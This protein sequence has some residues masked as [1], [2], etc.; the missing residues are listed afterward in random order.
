MKVE[1][2]SK[3]AVLDLIDAKFPNNPAVISFYTPTHGRDKVDYQNV[4]DNVFYVGV[5]DIGLESLSEYGYS[6]DMFLSEADD[7]A[8]FIYA[9]KEQNK[10]FICQCHFGR[11]RSAACAAAILEHFEK[12]GNDIFNDDQYYPNKLVYQKILSALEA[13][14]GK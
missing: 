1:I 6:S 14:H 11:G 7:L 10:D 8:E 4:C 2:F 9:A 5:H 12:K 3:G 13:R